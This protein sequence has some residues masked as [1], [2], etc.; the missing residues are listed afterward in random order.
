[1]TSISLNDLD[2]TYIIIKTVIANGEAKSLFCPEHGLF[3]FVDEA[4]ETML[5]IRPVVDTW[6][7]IGCLFVLKDKEIPTSFQKI[8]NDDREIKK[9]L[10]ENDL[11]DDQEHSGSSAKIIDI[12]EIFKENAPKQE[13]E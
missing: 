13:K 8:L 10:H 11:A 3:T 9:I 5:E 4:V 6:F 7:S 1:M 2:R 12:Q